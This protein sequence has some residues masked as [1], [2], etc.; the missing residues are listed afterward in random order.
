MEIRLLVLGVQDE[1]GE[2]AAGPFRDLVTELK[3]APGQRRAEADEDDARTLLALFGSHGL[4]VYCSCRCWCAKPTSDIQVQLLNR[5]VVCV[6][7][8]RR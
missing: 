2:R 4:S 5:G 7:R 1:K 8:G 3:K 6:H